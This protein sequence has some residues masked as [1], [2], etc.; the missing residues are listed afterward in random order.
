MTIPFS[1]KKGC[2]YS[3]IVRDI[4][5]SRNLGFHYYVLIKKPDLAVFIINSVYSKRVYIYLS[6]YVS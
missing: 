6:L 1:C 3:I 5:F 4:L 2:G